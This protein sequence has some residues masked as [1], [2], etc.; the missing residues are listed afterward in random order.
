MKHIKFY[1]CTKRHKLPN[2]HWTQIAVPLALPCFLFLHFITVVAREAI[3]CVHGIFSSKLIIVQF[4]FQHSR[5]KLA[6]TFQY[7]LFWFD[8]GNC[9][10][11]LFDLSGGNEGERPKD[12]NV[13]RGG[14]QA[15]C[16][17]PPCVLNTIA[18]ISGV[19]P[20]L[21]WHSCAASSST[22]IVGFVATIT[23]P[24]TSLYWINLLTL[25]AGSL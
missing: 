16:T 13:F 9:V 8:C 21:S 11:I 15:T 18:V 25:R 12:T 17:R 2:D 20:Y 1:K 5:R 10:T 23:R 14:C 3:I 7:F 22:N 4:Y 19:D 24:Q 6:I